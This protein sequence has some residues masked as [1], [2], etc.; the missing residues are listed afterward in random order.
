PV[1]QTTRHRILGVIQRGNAE[2]LVLDTPGIHRPHSRLG[3]VLNQRARDA[4]SEAD[5]VVYVTSVGKV[6]RG[7]ASLH[8]G[9][10]I[11]LADIGMARPVIGVINKVDT[12]RE[13]G[14]LLPLMKE[15]G[16]VRNFASIVPISALRDDG[17]DRVL[18]EAAK[19]IPPAA[20]RF[21][22]DEITDRSTRFF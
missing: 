6:T 8:P 18:D 12:L 4:I 19:L 20:H 22:P 9:D 21:D 17:V 15:L 2:L 10:R 14:A 5:V 11:L 13:R 3:K 7:A 16:R 1:P